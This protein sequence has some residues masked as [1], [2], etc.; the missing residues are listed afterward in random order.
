MDTVQA[1][2]GATDADG[3]LTQSVGRKDM[4]NKTNV[5]ADEIK[6]ALAKRHTDDL[7]HK[8][9]FLFTADWMRGSMDQW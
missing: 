8:C 4:S 1:E 6:R 7:F 9:L 5:R 2:D 3:H